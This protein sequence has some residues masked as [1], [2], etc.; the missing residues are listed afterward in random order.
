MGYAASAKWKDLEEEN[1]QLQPKFIWGGMEH[2]DER[3][4]VER[5]KDGGERERERDLKLEMKTR[6]N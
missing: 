2:N 6:D 4:D 1:N 3:Q 5:G